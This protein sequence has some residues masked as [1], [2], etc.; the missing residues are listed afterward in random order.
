MEPDLPPC[1]SDALDRAAG[2]GRVLVLGPMDAGKSSFL[3]ALAARR[4]G[5]ALLDLDPGQK[6]IGPPGSASLGAVAPELRLDRFVFLGSTAVR[7]F[8]PLLA[9]ARSL[10][11]SAEGRPLAVNTSGYVTGPGAQL[12]RMTIEAMRP[13]LVVAIGLDGP[14]E[15]T[16]RLPPSPFARRKSS[17]RRR[18]LRQLGFEAAMAGAAELALDPSSVAF[19]PSRPAPFPAGQLPV[20][21]LG[22]AFGEDME[23]GILRETAPD[24]IRI[25]VR[26][27]RRPVARVRLGEMW[28]G[29]SPDG[30]TL[31]DALR[32]AWTSG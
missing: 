28:A 5:L 8:G 31:L 18:A 17:A 21:A 22:D 10:A 26:A 20:C 3:L 1:W 12:Q 6:M 32:P 2:A 7:A 13:D 19:S 30:F 4:P 25:E 15:R 23:I 14:S 11:A 16:L 9:A 24:S 29:E 27:P